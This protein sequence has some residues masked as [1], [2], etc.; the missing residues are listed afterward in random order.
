MSSLE[1]T[2]LLAAGAI[3]CAI[4]VLIREHRRQYEAD[5]SFFMDCFQPFDP[6][7][8]EAYESEVPMDQDEYDEMMVI[9]HAKM[10]EMSENHSFFIENSDDVE[11]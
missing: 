8:Q 7:Y 11:H 10:Q 6:H 1:V 4:A 9:F 5:K 2:I 3:V